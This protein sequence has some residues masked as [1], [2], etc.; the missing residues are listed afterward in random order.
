VVCPVPATS[1]R[2]GDYGTLGAASG[3][4]DAGAHLQAG[5]VGALRPALSRTGSLPPGV[6]DMRELGATIH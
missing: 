2:Q 6:A 5:S 4:P 3:P 1:R